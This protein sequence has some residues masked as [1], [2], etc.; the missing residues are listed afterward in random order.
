MLSTTLT[1]LLALGAIQAVA[2][3]STVATLVTAADIAAANAAAPAGVSDTSIRMVDAGG[4]NI[5]I[6]LVKRPAT[7]RSSAI[8]HHNQTEIYHVIEGAGTLVTGGAIV[9]E[10]ELAADS[11]VVINLT[12]PS[13]AGS[14]IE[15]GE[16]RQIAKGDMLIIPAGVAHGFTEITEDI[17]YLVVRVDP[18][19]LVRVK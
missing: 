2:T 10:R 12:G 9:D 1:L 14:G 6:G 7:D 3:D 18:D 4:S 8:E 19:K 17:A 5:G 11:R 13:A 16:T 15:G